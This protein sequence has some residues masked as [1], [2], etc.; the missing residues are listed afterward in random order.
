MTGQRFDRPRSVAK[1]RIVKVTKASGLARV[2][3]VTT[4]PRP[5]VNGPRLV[6]IPMENRGFEPLTS[7]VRSQ[8]S[9]N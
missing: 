9:T 7:A 3:S 8:R 1:I 5:T 6:D 2:A 4:A